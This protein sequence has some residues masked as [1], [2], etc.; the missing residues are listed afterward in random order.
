[1]AK[2]KTKKVTARVSGLSLKRSG[3]GWT[4]SWKVPTSM[5]K[6]TKSSHSITGLQVK[7]EASHSKASGWHALRSALPIGKSRTSVSSWFDTG[8]TKSP[9]NY[10]DRS[11]YHPVTDGRKLKAMRVAVRGR[12]GGNWGPWATATYYVEAPSAPSMGDTELDEE[13]GDVSVKCS[14]SKTDESK[15]ERYRVRYKVTTER[16]TD[17]GKA[18]GSSTYSGNAPSSGSGSEECTITAKGTNWQLLGLNE[19]AR[20]T[21]EAWAQGLGGD[22]SHV[23]RSKL[24][25]WA[26]RPQVE[27]VTQ[28]QGQGG[29]GAVFVRIKALDTRYHPAKTLQL[30]YV[31]T[32]ATNTSNI[33]EEEWKDVSGAVADANE[34]GLGCRWDQVSTTEQGVRTYVRVKS[35]ADY[36]Q[37][38]TCS[39]PVYLDKMYVPRQDSVTVDASAIRVTE[40]SGS[41]TD[42][43]AVVARV[44]W[45]DHAYNA[46]EVSWSDDPDAWHTNK[47]PDTYRMPDVT[48]DDGPT[49][50]D[51]TSYSG[52]AWVKVTGLS[53]S[54]RYHVKARRY[55]TSDDEQRTGWSDVASGVTGA[56]AAGVSVMVPNVVAEGEA[57]PV[58]WTVGGDAPQEAWAVTVGG[59]VAAGA[60]GQ[61]SS[62]SVDPSWLSSGQ[63]AVEVAVT[64][65]GRQVSGRATCL[66]RERPTVSVSTERVVAAKPHAVTLS[67]TPGAT[68]VVTLSSCGATSQRPD[69][70]DPQPDGAAVWTE[71]VEVGDD[72]T[73]ATEVPATC[74]LVDGARYRLSAVATDS[75]GLS[76]DVARPS[77]TVTETDGDGTTRTVATDQMAVA[78]A[79]QAL[80]P[81]EATTR[82]DVDA[83]ATSVTIWPGTPDGWFLTGDEEP[84][85]GKAYYDQAEDGT[86]VAVTDPD[87]TAMD[88]YWERDGYAAGDG[89]A[90]TDVCDVYRS[91]PDGRQLVAEG[92]AFGSGV[93]DRWAPFGE[94]TEYVLC[95]RTADG[96]RDW[97][98]YGYELPGDHVRFDWGTR[99]VALLYDLEL[100]DSWEKGFEARSYLDGTTDG[101][102]SDAT[103]RTATVSASLVRGSSATELSALRDMATYAGPVFVRT[104]EGLAYEADVEVK[105]VSVSAASRVVPT[106][107]DVTEVR[108]RTFVCQPSDLVGGTS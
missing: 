31:N 35:V 70:S 57:L 1:M 65:S 62:C 85:E 76:S 20:V 54:T 47:E 63:V 32:E 27:S 101:W 106:S 94:S 3:N 7:M 41:D 72:G 80:A 44:A 24:V 108:C 22:S 78:W 38:Y 13:T 26:A 9:R 36:P 99:S 23:K 64:V 10:F 11:A 90:S 68:A 73:V 58:S 77:W 93:T 29:N 46:T 92:V 88:G 55:L 81:S 104:P 79:H 71:A 18:S 4:A 86:F 37:M 96:D 66:V 17:S 89:P 8:G 107:F 53:E 98:A 6:G 21:V 60:D 30:Q 45:N 34:R 2:S 19:W 42:P 14:L 33:N 74:D 82:I 95:T 49:E 28:D 75:Y 100:D 83:E 87:P 51:G 40:V 102:W 16:G 5:S 97:H 84:V 61:A 43:K 39:E 59:H 67:G 69:G 91:T 48:W 103:R 52:S 12:N 105:G 56:A 15:R 50:F 25:G